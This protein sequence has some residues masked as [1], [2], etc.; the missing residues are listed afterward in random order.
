[1]SEVILLVIVLFI[2]AMFLL[3]YHRGLI[4]IG[5]SLVLTVTSMILAFALAAPLK[6][7]IKNNTPIYN[8]IKT[9][10]EKQVDKEIDSID[11]LKLPDTIIKDLEKHNTSDY[12]TEAGVDTLNEYIVAYLADICITM[13]SYIILFIAIRLASII[14]MEIAGIFER[15]PVIAEINKFV[16]GLVGLVYGIVIIWVIFLIITL[17]QTTALG[18]IL[19]ESISNDPFLNY[20]YSTNILLKFL[21]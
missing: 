11:E 8:N 14:I 13:L 17:A 2:V 21:I 6:N 12:K 9:N 16:G 3:G 15:L 4:R 7:Y 20:I 5:L 1:M 19:M 10:I 18:G